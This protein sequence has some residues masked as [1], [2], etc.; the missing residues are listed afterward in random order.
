MNK[1]EIIK[2]Y[3]VYSAGSYIVQWLGVVSGILLRFTR[4]LLCGDMAGIKYYKNL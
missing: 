2:N 4:T 3:Y 1:R